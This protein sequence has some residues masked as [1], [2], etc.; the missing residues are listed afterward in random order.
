MKILVAIIIFVAVGWSAG[1]FALASYVGSSAENLITSMRD[2]GTDI[3]CA[4]RN[5]S[6]FPFSMKVTCETVEFRSPEMLE[7]VSTGRMAAG[8]ELPEF[9]RLVTDLASP[10]TFGGS[11]MRFQDAEA[12]VDMRTDGGFDLARIRIPSPTLI[13]ASVTAEAALFSGEAQ[14]DEQDLT[15][16]LSGDDVK[17]NVPQIGNLPPASISFLATLMDGYRDMVEL[18]LSWRTVLADGGKLNLESIDL[19]TDGGGR[20]MISGDIELLPDGRLDGP[21]RIA[22]SNPDALRRWARPFGP[23][24]EQ[25][26]ATLTQAVNGMG[27]EQD[28]DGTSMRSIDVMLDQGDLRLGFI[29]IAKIPPLRLN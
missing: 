3:A 9:Q 6:G 16:K 8:I 18:G 12:V 20:L 29:R 5:T 13:L 4:D 1:W 26:V 19:Q 10:V 2:R 23:Q 22:V 7:P 25:A 28:V 14:R 21:V 15:I 24:A 27:L 11:E 17:A